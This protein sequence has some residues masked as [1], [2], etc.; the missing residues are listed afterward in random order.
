[1]AYFYPLVTSVNQDS[2]ESAARDHAVALNAYLATPGVGGK[3]RHVH[4]QAMTQL[5]T[6]MRIITTTILCCNED[7]G[8]DD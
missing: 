6:N 7:E 5:N 8:D 3:Q 4:T 1:M 2:P